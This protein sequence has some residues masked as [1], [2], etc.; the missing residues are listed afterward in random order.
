MEASHL[1]HH[2]SH[3]VSSELGVGATVVKPG[4]MEERRS[5]LS[6]CD[7]MKGSFGVTQKSGSNIAE[8]VT[9]WIQCDRPVCGKWR[10]IATEIA[11][12]IGDEDKWCDF[13]ADKNL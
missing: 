13:L 9:T 7:E 11:E 3:K 5:P 2:V 10:R 6:I 4:E 1:N 8:A 12:G